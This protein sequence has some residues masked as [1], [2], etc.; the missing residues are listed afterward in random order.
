[1]V[2]H[3]PELSPRFPTGAT[4]FLRALTRH[5]EREWFREHRSEFDELI[6]APM[7]AVIDRLAIDFRTFLPDLI[8]SPRV[9]RYRIYRDTRFS[10]NKAPLKNHVAAVFP[11]RFLPRHEGPGLYFE[12]ASTWVY[13][14][15]GI[16]MP[17]PE[18]LQLLREHI[19]ARHRELTRIVE[20]PTFRRMFGAIQGDRLSRMPRGF[21]PD[22]PAGELLRLKQVLIGREW[23]ASFASSPRFYP[24]LLRTFRTVAP[25]IKFLNAPLRHRRVDP[26]VARRSAA[27]RV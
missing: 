11:S 5:N 24:E 19:A 25:I 27:A 17:Q 21:P 3:K 10:E 20:A 14:G 2:P 15:G 7:N 22:H 8:A 4:R 16:Y 23:P 1:M 12:I 18:I 9:S 6:D 26:L 13:A